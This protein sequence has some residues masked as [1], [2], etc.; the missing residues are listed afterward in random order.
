[1]KDRPPQGVPLHFEFD[2]IEVECCNFNLKGELVF[3]CTAKTKTRGKMNI[4]CVCSIQTKPTMI[5]CRK[6][7]KIPKKAEVVSISKYDKIWL[8]FNNNV[9]EWNLLTG[10]T[11]ILSKNVYEVI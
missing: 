6:I 1:M 8:H 7:Y 10:H 2:I 5:K 4:V 11:M 3:F 9:Y